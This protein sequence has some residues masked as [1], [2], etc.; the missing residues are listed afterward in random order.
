MWSDK[1]GNSLYT[2]DSNTYIKNEYNLKGEKLMSRHCGCK[3]K[4]RCDRKVVYPTREDVKHTR[5][6]E[7]VCHV[8]PS[9]TRVINNHTVRNVHYYPHSTSYENRVNEVDVMGAS[10]GPGGNVRGARGGGYGDVRGTR[11]YQ[12][13]YR[14]NRVA[15]RYCGC[16]GHCK[17]GCRRRRGGFWI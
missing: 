14:D 8:H 17:C 5:S 16:R 3:G 9:H 1:V 6:E 15:G 4:C 12:C 7:T 10:E 13:G 11:D 2:I